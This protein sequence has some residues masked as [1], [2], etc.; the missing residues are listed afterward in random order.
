[1]RSR[2]RSSAGTASA[3]SASTSSAPRGAWCSIERNGTRPFP[4]D[5]ARAQRAGAN[6]RKSNPLTTIV[7]MEPTGDAR[8]LE[9]R[10]Y[11]IVLRRRKGVI[12]ATTV[13]VVLAVLVFSLLETSIY[14]SSA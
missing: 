7:P 3:D 11:L 12:I 2:S 13:L 1:M 14:S 8:E 5:F 10:D 4:G 6:R 9:F